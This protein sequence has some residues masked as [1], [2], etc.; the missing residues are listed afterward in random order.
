MGTL[1]L[2]VDLH[3]RTQMVCWMN[4]GDGELHQ[5]ELDHQDDDVGG[6]YTQLPRP[7]IVGVESC[8]YTV[9]FHRLVEE[10][11]HELRVGDARRIR[12]FAKRR[13]KNDRRDAALLLELLVK[14]DSPAVHRPRGKSR[15]GVLLLRGR[16]RLGR[17]RPKVEERVQSSAPATQLRLGV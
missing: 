11:G 2:G 16:E 7:A 1:Y 12:Q 14:G 15:E 6:F 10:T 9:W 3:V 17:M 4:A 8:G 13:Q 5:R